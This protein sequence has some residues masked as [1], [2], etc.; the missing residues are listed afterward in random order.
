MSLRRMRACWCWRA[1]DAGPSG[2]S[3]M[4]EDDG[5]LL[6]GGLGWGQ[7]ATGAPG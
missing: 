2:A 4:A 1:G 3:V 5:L 7:A 6:E